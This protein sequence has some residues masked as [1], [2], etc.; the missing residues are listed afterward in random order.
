MG[1]RKQ[2]KW[3][4]IYRLEEFFKPEKKNKKKTYRVVNDM[5]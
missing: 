3:I 2:N 4:V 5:K 1:I